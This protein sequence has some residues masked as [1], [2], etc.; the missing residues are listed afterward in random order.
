MK[1]FI[2]STLFY[3]CTL[4]VVQSQ[5]VGIGTIS[6]QGIFH[7]DSHKNTSGATNTSDDVIVDTNGNLG[8]GLITPQTKIDISEK[9]QLKDG[10][11]G[12]NKALVSDNLGR[13]F[14]SP[15]TLNARTEWIFS[16][17]QGGYTLTSSLP[18][19]LPGSGYF[20]ENLIPG[21]T[22]SSNYITIPPGTYIVMMHGGIDTR[23]ESG[24]PV[25]IRTYGR[26]ALRYLGDTS[27]FYTVFTSRLNGTVFIY[28]S[29]TTKSICI[30]YATRSTHIGILKNPPHTSATYSIS[31]SFIKL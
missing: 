16:S 9:F 4:T 15:F 21:V 20:S 10:T 11:E 3:L 25:V 12:L 1:K 30:T 23:V 28:S 31:I 2:Y 13:A 26:Y 22:T 19:V 7:I 14:W 5:S 24:S 18:V 17:P 27:D 29:T 6:P 8:I